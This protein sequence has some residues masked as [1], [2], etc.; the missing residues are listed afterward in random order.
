MRDLLSTS[1]YELAE[2][3]GGGGGGGM[4]FFSRNLGQR[5]AFPPALP[6]ETLNTV[7]AL[8]AEFSLK[9][10]IITSVTVN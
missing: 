1:G 3:L 8:S 6:L 9:H 7:W 2:R 10:A 4:G 5:P